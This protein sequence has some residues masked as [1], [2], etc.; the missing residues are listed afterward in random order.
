MAKFFLSASSLN[1]FNDC[2]R[3][4]WLA[5]NKK[6][7]RPRGPMPSVA[8]GIDLVVKEIFDH[9]RALN[10]L[11]EFLDGKIP[12]KLIPLLPRTMYAQ[13]SPEV[14]LVGH[15][16]EAIQFDDGSYAPL[17]HKTK[18][19]DPQ[20]I[21]PTYKLQLAVY[22]LLLNEKFK[23][24]KDFGYLIYFYPVHNEETHWIRFSGSLKR[25][26]LQDH[27][28]ELEETIRAAAECLKRPLPEPSDKCEFCAWSRQVQ[29]FRLSPLL[30]AAEPIQPGT[31][32]KEESEPPSAVAHDA[33][34]LPEET[35]DAE[36]ENP[37]TLF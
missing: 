21:H 7:Y 13:F 29:D 27:I 12:G 30:E 9:Y 10:Q 6:L 37:D 5:V 15:L 33:T 18:N 36:N 16:D 34:D 35:P 20:D 22:R 31:T 8:T 26:D 1:M 32:S 23:K 11:P 3:C 24:V 28:K 19:R 2:P 14:T 4:F 25:I 17:D